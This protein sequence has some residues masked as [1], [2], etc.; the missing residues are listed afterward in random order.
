[1][2][3][4]NYAYGVHCG[5]FCFAW[6]PSILPCLSGLTQRHWATLGTR[7]YMNVI[8]NQH[9]VFRDFVKTMKH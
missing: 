1:M 3:S 4:Q 5:V 8:F 2:Q 9:I 6:H 7:K